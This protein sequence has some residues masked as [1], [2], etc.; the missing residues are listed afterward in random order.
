MTRRSGAVV[1]E[2]NSPRRQPVPTSRRCAVSAAITLT[3]SA[4]L[5]PCGRAARRST[6]TEKQQPEEERCYAEEKQ[7]SEK[8]NVRGVGD[9]DRP[10][11]IRKEHKQERGAG[12]EDPNCDAEDGGQRVNTR[13]RKTLHS[14]AGAVA[15]G[16]PSSYPAGSESGLGG[17]VTSGW[18]RPGRR[19]GRAIRAR[20]SVRC[21]WL[22]RSRVL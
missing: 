11:G 14:S 4:I 7:S 6:A 17:A 2:G 13:H 8:H 5:A 18:L 22:A 19:L 15:A 21:R 16:G 10:G 12:Q 1:G 3:G 9:R 20:C